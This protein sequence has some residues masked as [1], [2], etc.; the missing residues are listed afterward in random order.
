MRD[1]A[2][3]ACGHRKVST[4]SAEGE[5]TCEITDATIKNEVF[6]VASH[7]RYLPAHRSIRDS[8]KSF[9]VE[10]LVLQL[11]DGHAVH[12]KILDVGGVLISN[13]TG[14][15]IDNEHAEV[16]RPLDLPSAWPA[17]A[18]SHPALEVWTCR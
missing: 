16:G 14:A 13:A 4:S 7:S 12:G 9:E 17:A 1:R 5:F 11:L 2:T 6:V 10:P 8:D 18:N 3:A 15:V